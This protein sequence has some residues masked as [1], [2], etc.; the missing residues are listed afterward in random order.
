M[1]FRITNSMTT[2]MTLSDI[3]NA[4]QRLSKSQ[5]RLS[6][7]KQ[8]TTP[9]D[10]PYGTV[11]ALDLR[12]SLAENR[13]YQANVREASAWHDVTD[14]A[15]G[16]VGDYVLRARELLVRGANDSQGEAA[17]NAAALELDQI[18]EALKS[19]GNT[20]YAGRYVFS[21]TKT[22]T[23]PYQVG[24]ADTYS[25][26]S[27]AIKRSI[28]SNVTLQVNSIGQ[29]VIGDGSSGLI[30]NLRE[31]A[32]DLRAG[33]TAKLQGADLQK[34]DAAHD[35]VLAERATVGAR[36]QRLET[37]TARLGQLEETQNKL[38]SELED[39]DM[40]KT[41]TDYSMQSA[42]YEAALKAGAQ[43]I[44]SSLLDFLR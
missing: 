12:S 9:S 7:G 22:Q 36:S 18:V 4:A 30:Q 13:Q 5:E 32:A 2:R 3:E 17:R 6:S 44:H 34:L 26:D 15:L 8:L 39:A 11:R 41:M 38:Q 40:A 19:E 35:V 16:H 27:G 37:A 23:A 42:V 24:G 10:D 14:T 21:G 25:G 1:S 29:N 28:S 33:D 20:Q 43:I 31:I